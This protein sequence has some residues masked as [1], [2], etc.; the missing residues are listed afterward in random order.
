MRV[1]KLLILSPFLF[2][3]MFTKHSVAG[4]VTDLEWNILNQLVVTYYKGS[5]SLGTTAECTAF[6]D[7]GN[8]IG[9]GIDLVQGGVARVSINV[10][11]KYVGQKL[12]VRCQ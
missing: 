4:E 1:K 3:L 7:S 11:K 12:R 10:P 6:N 5:S 2:S 8:P 9:G